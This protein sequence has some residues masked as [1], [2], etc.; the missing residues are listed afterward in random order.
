MLAKLF[1]EHGINTTGVG[2]G[3]EISSIL[4]DQSDKAIVL[5]DYYT[6]ELDDYQRGVVRY[7]FDQLSP[8]KHKIELKAW[9]TYNNSNSEIIEFVVVNEADIALDHILNYPNHYLYL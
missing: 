9:D 7:P 8:G 3:H 2:I 6:S 4:D 1:D 5:N